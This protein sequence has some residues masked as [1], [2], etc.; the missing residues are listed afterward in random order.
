MFKRFDSQEERR[1]AGGT[2]FIEL[3]FCLLPSGTPLKRIVSGNDHWRD[4]SLYVDGMGPFFSTY[5][6]IFG[7][8]VHQ[9]MTTGLLDTWGITYYAPGRIGDIQERASSIRPEGYEVL[10]A[11]LEEAK[12]YNGFYILGV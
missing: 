7:E 12:E 4:D 1:K 8:G 5:K 10:V 2:C 6:D 9:N 11:W 3:Q